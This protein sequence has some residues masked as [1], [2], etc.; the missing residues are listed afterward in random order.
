MDCSPPGSSVHGILQARTLDWVAIFVSRG[1]QD[2]G[3]ELSLPHYRQTL[4]SFS[5]QLC[6]KKGFPVVLGVKNLPANA[7]DIRDGV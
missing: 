6:Q 4:Y 7:R 5:H 3:I 1:S 2:P